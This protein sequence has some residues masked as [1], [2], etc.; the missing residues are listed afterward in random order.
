[1]SPTIL[2]K[3][4]E[5]LQWLKTVEDDNTLER[6]M[7]IKLVQDQDWWDLLSIDEKNSIENGLKDIDVCNVVHH[8]EVRKIYEKWLMK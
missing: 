3:K 6:I 2:E 1:M 4:N 5:L 7:E 8:G